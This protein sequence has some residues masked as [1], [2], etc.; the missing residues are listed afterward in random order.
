MACHPSGVS[1]IATLTR[2]KPSGRHR[3]F[4]GGFVSLLDDIAGIGM[5]TVSS[6]RMSDVAMCVVRRIGCSLVWITR[7][8]WDSICGAS[9]RSC[10]QLR[11]LD[12]PIC[13][14]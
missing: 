3:S 9:M 7:E 12:A 13:G 5:H 2:R 6:G 8:S 1:T 14:V 11:A 4:R 10:R